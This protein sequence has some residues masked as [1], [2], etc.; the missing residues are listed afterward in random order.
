[1]REAKISELLT[2]QRI[3][4]KNYSEAFLTVVKC[5]ETIDHFI[6]MLFSYLKSL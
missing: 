5:S 4:V 6:S 2:N 3:H 1:M